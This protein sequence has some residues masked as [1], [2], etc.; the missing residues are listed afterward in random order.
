MAQPDRGRSPDENYFRIQRI[1]REQCALYPNLE[2][3]A[4]E[5]VVKAFCWKEFGPSGYNRA[6]VS[7]AVN[8]ALAALTGTKG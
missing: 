4:L 8:A 1:A 2:Q 5:E 7:R 3:D 6:V